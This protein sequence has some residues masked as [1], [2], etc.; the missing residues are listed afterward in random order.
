VT[1]LLLKLGLVPPATFQEDE[2]FVSEA[3][4]QTYI[5]AL[6]H[7]DLIWHSDYL[8]STDEKSMTASLL[9]Y[10]RIVQEY[11]PNYAPDSATVD[12]HPSSQAALLTAFESLGL[13]ECHLHAQRSVN[14]DLATYR[15]RNPNVD[16]EFLA[17]IGTGTWAALTSSRSEEEF[18]TRINDLKTEVNADP[19]LLGRLDKLIGRT[20]KLMQ[21]LATPEVDTT[22]TNLDQSFKWLNRKFFQMQS[23]MSNE[24][25]SAFSNAWAIARNMWRFMADAKRAGSSPVELA[26]F[27]LQ[28]RC[29][30]EVVNLVSTRSLAQA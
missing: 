4:E 12:S 14:R 9:K 1:S 19:L 3:G 28:D 21:Y 5:A 11:F 6:H 26:G 8:Q 27:N 18:V 22:S 10:K 30:L 16:P 13:Q 24:G 20:K 2:K 7:N 25:A 29:W 15:R 17:N 23:F